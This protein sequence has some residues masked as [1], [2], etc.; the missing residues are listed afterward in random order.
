ML[1]LVS[2]DFTCTKSH[3]LPRWEFLDFGDD[4]YC[5][6]AALL[7]PTGNLFV[8]K[9][10]NS[11]KRNGKI[12]R[13]EGV[14]FE[15]RA[16]KVF[17]SWRNIKKATFSCLIQFLFSWIQFFS[18][19]NSFRNNIATFV[20][21][22]YEYYNLREKIFI[23]WEL[24]IHS[25]V[26]SSSLIITNGIKSIKRGGWVLALLQKEGRTQ[27]VW[28][29]GARGRVPVYFRFSF[30]SLQPHTILY[31]YINCFTSSCT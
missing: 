15:N 11:M 4:S 26:T 31:P 28:D 7:D 16:C 1:I 9:W 18:N 14:D 10:K 23:W 19:N 22:I 25:C 17:A 27:R 2:R 21:V 12:Q 24:K 20:L 30:T 29:G 6:S 13:K 8:K 3:F 5:F